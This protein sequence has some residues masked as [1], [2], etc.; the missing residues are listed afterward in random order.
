MKTNESGHKFKKSEKQSMKV[1][2]CSDIVLVT[3]EV[4]R[5]FVS[6]RTKDLKVVLCNPSEDVRDVVAV[7]TATWSACAIFSG[8]VTTATANRAVNDS[9]KSP[10]TC[11][12]W[13]AEPRHFK[14]WHLPPVA[15]GPQR[16]T[17]I[18]RWD[19]E[20]SWRAINQMT[21]EAFVALAIAHPVDVTG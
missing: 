13:R 15:L 14:A 21:A 8:R 11:R 7:A 3:S 12:R 9:K 10:Q 18:D 6:L 5:F 1:I 16:L 2:A 4:L 19:R 20:P 17:T